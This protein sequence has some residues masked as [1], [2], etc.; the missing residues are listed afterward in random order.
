MLCEW[1]GAE[2]SV[3]AMP[4]FYSAVIRVILSPT[5]LAFYV[6]FGSV[7]LL[8]KIFEEGEVSW[9]IEICGELVT[10]CAVWLDCHNILVGCG[11]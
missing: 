5:P 10:V 8:P 1:K 9:I 6:L 7:E 4:T 2:G 11:Y 3:S